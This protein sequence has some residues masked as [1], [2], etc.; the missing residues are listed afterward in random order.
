LPTASST[1]NAVKTRK[2][3]FSFLALNDFDAMGINLKRLLKPF[4]PKG[5]QWKKA[6]SAITSSVS[7]H[8]NN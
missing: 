8:A 4:Y 7:L 2:E 1:T 3:V 6:V 5:G